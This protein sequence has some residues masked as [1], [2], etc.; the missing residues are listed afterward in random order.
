M[1]RCE[2][3]KGECVFEIIFVNLLIVGF[4]AFSRTLTISKYLLIHVYLLG[5]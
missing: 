3:L 4:L 5:I 1:V 2:A